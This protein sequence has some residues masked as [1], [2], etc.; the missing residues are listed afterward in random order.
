MAMITTTAATATVAIRMIT[1]IA[2]HFARLRARGPGLWMALWLALSLLLA[3]HAGLTHRVV[4][5]SLMGSPVSV[6][7]AETGTADHGDAGPFAKK[8]AGHSCV[9]FDGATVA[10]SHCIQMPA[11][12]LA[13]GKPVKPA[14]LAWRWPDLPSAHPFRSR[15]PPAHTP[16]FA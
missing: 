14:N 2:G 1:E 11:L 7:I 8:L 13:F 10:D 6:L 15:A 5:G 16:A 12:A 9:L 4:H 3:Q